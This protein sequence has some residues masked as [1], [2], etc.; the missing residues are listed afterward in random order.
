L[1]TD[2]QRARLN[3]PVGWLALYRFGLFF[4]APATALSLVLW[5]FERFHD[6]AVANW[7]RIVPIL[8][9]VL[10][11]TGYGVYVGGLLSRSNPTGVTHARQHLALVLISS[12]AMAVLLAW[13]QGS[14]EAGQAV[15]GLVAP[16]I[17][18][19]YFFTSRRVLA[20]YGSEVFTK[21]LSAKFVTIALASVMAVVVLSTVTLQGAPDSAAD[22]TYSPG[23]QGKPSTSTEQVVQGAD[24]HSPAA[25]TL[26]ES[27][28]VVAE[29]K[30]SELLSRD[31]ISTDDAF[32]QLSR[33]ASERNKTLPMMVDSATELT[34]IAVERPA[35]VIYLN[36]LV[37]ETAG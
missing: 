26:P 15:G 23:L 10:V 9:L 7:L 35:T 34:G 3:G 6:A 16:P 17:W 21:R 36:R 27:K 20:T 2:E 22:G 32:R 13:H 24:V 18:L 31:T 11:P 19:L 37:N 1:L 33:Y 5:A 25:T 4:G 28:S 14:A 8:L 12:I 30:H 29:P